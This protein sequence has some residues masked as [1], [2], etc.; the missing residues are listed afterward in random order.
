MASPVESGAC[1]QASS[2]RPLPTTPE[3]LSKPRGFEFLSTDH[4]AA[5][6]PPT[7][8]CA[9]QTARLRDAFG[10]DL[11]GNWEPFVASTLTLISSILCDSQ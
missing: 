10:S 4:E 3:G 1:G 6:P 9:S 11:E 5:V 7:P 2:S 8:R